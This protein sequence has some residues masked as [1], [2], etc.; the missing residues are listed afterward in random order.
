VRCLDVSYI[1]IVIGKHRTAH[2]THENRLVL[3]PQII[4][5]LGN[6]LVQRT[7][8]ATG[9]VMRHFCVAGFASET[10]VETTGFLVQ[11]RQQCSW[12]QL[13]VMAAQGAQGETSGNCITSPAPL[14]AWASRPLAAHRSAPGSRS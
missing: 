13:L 7:M 12:N 11:R 10:L 3:N 6:Q 2:R 9:A 5:R 8:P 4:D 1:E 14:A